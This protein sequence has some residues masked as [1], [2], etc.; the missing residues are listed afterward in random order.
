M[1]T[2]FLARAPTFD[3]GGLCESAKPTQ[4]SSW[5]AENPIWV[6]ENQFWVAVEPLPCER[7]QLRLQDD[8]CS[9]PMMPQP[10]IRQRTFLVFG[11]LF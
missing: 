5:V 6:A 10:R 1:S 2:T 7:S 11:L 4:P 9:L 3:E 8:Q